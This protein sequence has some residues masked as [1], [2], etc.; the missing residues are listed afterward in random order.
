MIRSF[1][2]SSRLDI[3]ALRT[4][5]HRMHPSQVAGLN[6]DELLSSDTDRAA[7]GEIALLSK[8]MMPHRET[9]VSGG[10]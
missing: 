2:D 7:V 1:I 3:V 9:F 5:I 8:S 10:A 4:K 6:T